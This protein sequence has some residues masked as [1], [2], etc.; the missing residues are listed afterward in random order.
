M[1][2]EA[3]GACCREAYHVVSVSMRDPVV[4]KQPAFI[5]RRG[6]KFEILREGDHCAALAID[7]AA[8][9]SSRYHCRIYED[10][11]TTCREFAAGGN[12]CL[13]ARRRVGLSR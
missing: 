1:R 4:W 3:C 5:V 11:P 10:R 7:P 6:Y 9:A 12:H 8:P 13:Q 2:C